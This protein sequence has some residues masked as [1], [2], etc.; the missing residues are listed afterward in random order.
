MRMTRV[1][2]QGAVVFLAVGVLVTVAAPV[3]AATF[4]PTPDPAVDGA[5]NSLRAAVGAATSVA[6]D[7]IDLQAGGT[8]TL[9]CAGGDQLTHSNTPLT[10]SAPS[11]AAATIRQT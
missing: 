3:G 1:L 10:I 6:G 8:Y 2:S 5:A 4:T 11:G 9:T 7:E